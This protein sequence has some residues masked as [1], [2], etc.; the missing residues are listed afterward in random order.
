MSIAE[1]LTTIAENQQMVYDAGM[2]QG[3]QAEYDRFWEA[4]QDN[5]KR[6][7]YSFGFAYSSFNDDNFKPKY[8]LQPTNADRM[9]IGAKGITQISVDLSKATNVYWAFRNMSN[10]QHI[11]KCD[12]TSAT[13][14][15]GLF[16]FNSYLQSIEE[17]VSHDGLV[18][19]NAFVYD[20]SLTDVTFSGVISTNFT[21][22]HSRITDATVQSIIDHLKDL[23]GTTAQTLTF[24]KDVGN[25]LT[26][27]QKDAIFAKNWTLVY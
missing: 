26:Q 18:W 22:A 24:H 27:A 5:G 4:W 15:D 9:F 23:T 10:I 25:K 8:P 11:G 7:D 17:I 13:T 16:G 2:E 12:L 3:K 19:D 20:T 1:K 6:T 14:T 21:I